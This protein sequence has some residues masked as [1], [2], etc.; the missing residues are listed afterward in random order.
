MK[1][2]PIYVDFI[3]SLK[4]FVREPGTLFFSLVFP[5]ILMLC[6]GAIFGGGVFKSD[7]YIQDNDGSPLSATFVKTINATEAFN[8]HMI[9]TSKDPDAYIKSNHLTGILVIPHGFGDTVRQNLAHDSTLAVPRVQPSAFNATNVPSETVVSVDQQTMATQPSQSPSSLANQSTA[10]LVLKVDQSQRSAPLV[11]GVLNNI[12]SS[13]NARLTGAGQVVGL[14]SQEVIST[15][16]RYIDFFVPG[17]IGL[18]VLA[19][20]V[21]NTVAINTRYRTN[22]ILR[23]L[24]TTPLTKTEWIASKIL[25]QAVRAFISTALI[26]IVA[27]LAFNVKVLPDVYSIILIFVGTMA[28]TGIGMIISRFVRDED[29]ANA[30][31]NAVT[32]PMFF[33]AGTFVPIESMPAY[34]QPIAR[35]L[36]LT[37]LNNG[38][39]DAMIFGD[40]ASALYNTS[41]VLVTGIVLFAIGSLVTDWRE[42]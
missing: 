25:S 11:T 19:S 14:K 3:S 13:F 7:L 26:I 30:A 32:F 17:V 20:G 23:K 15:Q 6:F 8:V 21:F 10:Y 38:L 27:I 9:G 40:A 5:I 12:I 31:A 2:S 18:T 28:F 37:Y 1:R 29:A 36:P 34:L 33:L 22:G 24:A 41:I 16:F 39:R 42:K 35:A 4:I